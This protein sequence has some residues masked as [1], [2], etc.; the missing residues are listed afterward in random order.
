MQQQEKQQTR[1]QKPHNV[2]MENR[3][4]IALTGVLDI[5]SFNEQGIIVLTELGV[6]IVKGEDLHINKLNVDSGDVSIE[7]NIAS[8]TY[9]DIHDKKTGSIIKSLFK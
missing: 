5:D 1:M 2:L 6:L 8:L 4:K 9:T 7:G 3:K